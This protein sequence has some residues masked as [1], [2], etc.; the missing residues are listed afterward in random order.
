MNHEENTNHNLKQRYN[1]GGG[2]GPAGPAAAG[3]MIDCRPRDSSSS[4]QY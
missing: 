2:A 4:A 1:S 3:P